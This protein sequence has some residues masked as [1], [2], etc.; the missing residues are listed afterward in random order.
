M[1]YVTSLSSFAGHRYP[2]P[3]GSVELG[4]VILIQIVNRKSLGLPKK[5]KIY[6]KKKS[7]KGWSFFISYYVYFHGKC[8]KKWIEIRNRINCMMICFG[9]ILTKLVL[10]AL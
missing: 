9:K 8:Y 3:V 7:K 5:A 2:R 10:L 4:E 1:I 6:V